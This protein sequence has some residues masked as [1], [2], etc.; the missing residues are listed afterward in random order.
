MS[1]AGRFSIRTLVAIAVV[2]VVAWLTLVFGGELAHASAVDREAAQ[3]RADNASFQAQIDAGNAEISLIQT[4]AFLSTEAR[5]F[6]MGRAGERLFALDPGAPA[7]AHIVPLGEEAAPAAAKTPLEE[8][9][10]LLF[11]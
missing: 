9:L 2:V 8:W 3:V 4:D 11:G 10:D 6:G 7:P 1:G 5:V